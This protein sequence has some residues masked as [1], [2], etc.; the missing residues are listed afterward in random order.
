MPL[1]LSP[2]QLA[3]NAR[4]DGKFN[5]PFQEQVDFLKQKLNLPTAHWDDI[6]SSAHDRAFIVAGAAKADLLTDFHDAINKAVADGK[7]IGAFKQEFESIVKK[8]GWEG[9]TGSDTVT[10]RD[11]RARVIYNTNMRASY[12]AGRYAQLTDPELL[13]SRPYWK[14]I[15]NDTVAHPRPLHQ[16]WNGTVLR[17]DDPWW[18]AHFAPNG[19]GCRCRITAVRATEYKGHPA[20]DDGTYTKTDRNG[21][22]HTLPQGVDYGWDYAPGASVT[23]SFKSLIDDKLIRLPAPV[24]AAMM[25]LL[26]PV[27]LAEIDASFS[28]WVDITLADG[29]S[30]NS[31][32]LMGWMDSGVLSGLAKQGKVPI[33]AE[34]YT[35]DRLLVGKKADRHSRDGDALSVD[36]WKSMP[37]ALADNPRVLLDSDTGNLLYVLPGLT[38]SRDI[39]IVLEMDFLQGKMKAQLN[40]AR[41]TFKI[42]VNALQDRRRYI[43][44]N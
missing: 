11:W 42:N 14:Y 7:S 28:A 2:T 10:G 33:T 15:H 21:T 6:R 12:A 19:F 30:K 40:L 34:I 22:V 18:Q 20:P 9:W 25:S 26:K 36:E 4:G 39:K 35:E 32:Q 37:S 24:G 17:Y 29:V 38:D 8:H 41:S 13:Q 43:P 44:L 5:R 1:N 31:A 16:S 23:Q 27:L 3:F